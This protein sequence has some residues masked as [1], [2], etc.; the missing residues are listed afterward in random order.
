[1]L[2]SLDVGRTIMDWWG[3][4]ERALAQVPH[5]VAGAVATG[6]Y[7]PE[8]ATRD[9]DIV[10]VSHAARRAEHAL[11]A[12]G[13]RMTGTLALVRGT[14]WQDQDGHELY[15]IAL[16]ELWAAEAV[17]AARNNRVAGIP[18][19]PLPYLVFMKLQAGRT[20]DLADVSRMLG[21]AAGDQ[22]EAARE[23]VRRFGDADDLAD[24]EQL[25]RMGRLERAGE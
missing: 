14:S 8:R 25:V 17:E 10:V 4:V 3:D 7:A 20:I 1:M 16:S 9:I 18:T 5:A 15:L 19:L 13:W 6:A 12:A 21:R 11:R 24:F 2:S 23:V 22:I